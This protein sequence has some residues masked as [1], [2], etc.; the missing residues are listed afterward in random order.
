MPQEENSRWKS[1]SESFSDMFEAFG[2]AISQIFDDPEL[3]GK[4]R[5]FG[6]S[7]VESAEAFGSRFKDEEVRDKFKEVAKA[8]QDFGRSMAECFRDDKDK[9]DVE[10]EGRE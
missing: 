4:A 5:E 7:A 2:N 3:K 10:T 8:A 1:A 6:R 9:R